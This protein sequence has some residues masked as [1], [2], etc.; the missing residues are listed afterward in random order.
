MKNRTRLRNRRRGFTLME[1][2]IVIALLGTIMGFVVMNLGDVLTGGKADIEKAKVQ[3][4]GSFD[5]ALQR[6]R[7]KIG[8]YPST[9]EGL[10]ALLAAPSGKEDRWGSAPYIKDESVLKDSYGNTYRYAYPG[11]HNTNGY[12]LWSVGPDGQDGTPDD[13][14]NWTPG[15]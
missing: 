12:D 7:M 9:E 1:I 2:L 13:I 6:Y 11:T 14:G 5:L 3:S 8:S 4:N 10:Q 15:K